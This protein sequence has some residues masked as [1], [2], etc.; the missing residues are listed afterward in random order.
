MYDYVL[1]TTDYEFVGKGFCLF[2][3]SSCR[4]FFCC[5]QKNI[6][7]QASSL[8]EQKPSFFVPVPIKF[9]SSNASC[10]EVEIEERTFLRKLDL[11]FRGALAVMGEAIMQITQ[12][13]FVGEKPM[14]NIRGNEYLKKLYQI[15]AVK[16]GGRP[17]V[18]EETQARRR[19]S[20]F[21]QGEEEVFWED[22]GK[23]EWELF[24]NANL[25]RARFL[26]FCRSKS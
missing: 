4:Q 20:V 18:Q 1:T 3:H 24:E 14:Y 10:V 11:G 21:V 6:S 9:S 25:T 13:V 26:D 19:E 5:A 22:S 2:Y 15:P 23:L 8:P 7:E 16:I 12:K 17:I